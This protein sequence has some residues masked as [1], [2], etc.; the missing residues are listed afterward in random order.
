M[1]KVSSNLQSFLSSLAQILTQ[2]RP[3]HGPPADQQSVGFG[4]MNF[5]DEFG[6]GKF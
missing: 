2:A 3:E 6:S 5:E 4:L 1:L